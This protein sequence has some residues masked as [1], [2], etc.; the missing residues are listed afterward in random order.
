MAPTRSG[1][2]V[3]RW[4]SW[5]PS[6]PDAAADGLPAEVRFLEFN[7]YGS[8]GNMGDIV[9]VVNAVRDTVLKDRPHVMLFNEVCLGQA[10][11]LWDEL[12]RRGLETSA[13]FGATTGR[14]NCTGAEGEQWYGNAVFVRG[15]GIGGPTLTVLPNPARASEQRAVIT[16]KALLRGLPVWVSA[17]HLATRDRQPVYNRR[18]TLELLRIQEEL[19]STGAA[20][21][22]GG[23]MNA[24]PGELRELGLPGE[25]FLE[26]DQDDNA[27]SFPRKKI[28]YIFLDRRHFS[29]PSGWVTRSKFSD[30]R[31]LKGTAT[32]VAG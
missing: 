23:D 21:V 19:A 11:R 26:V 18:Q 15:P 14:S 5:L 7:M 6:E 17:T 8:F 1:D 27:H 25:R 16:V 12:T 3:W 2:R 20:V 24:R 10:N 22:F 29:D 32:L 28:D 9:G 30:H 31:P 13:A 4:G